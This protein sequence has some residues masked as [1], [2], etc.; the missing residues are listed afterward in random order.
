MGT[1]LDLSVNKSTTSADTHWCLGSGEDVL[2]SNQHY[3]SDVEQPYDTSN[4]VELPRVQI[5]IPRV[6][7]VKLPSPK[8]INSTQREHSPLST[9]SSWSDL[10]EGTS[11]TSEEMPPPLRQQ[12]TQQQQQPQQSKTQGRG[13]KFRPCWLQ[14]YSWLK[15]DTL[16]D[17]MY[18]Q[19]CRKWSKSLP[20]RTSFA[21]GSRNFRHEIVLHHHKCKAHQMCMNMEEEEASSPSK[22]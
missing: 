20:V 14:S 19:F 3:Y 17:V 5:Q 13:N 7:R 22:L 11:R 21:E 1:G 9:A 6:S 16:Q 15:Y 4:Q 8:Y 12:V 18:C 2:Q 10:G